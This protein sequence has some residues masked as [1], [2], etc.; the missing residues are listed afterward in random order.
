M[1]TIGMPASYSW[2]K[3]P[4]ISASASGDA[5]LCSYR[6]PAISTA[7]TRSWIA[8]PTTSSRTAANSSVLDRPRIVL[9]TC[10]SEVWRN[11]MYG[12]NAAEGSMSERLRK[13]AQQDHTER[14]NARVDQRFGVP[15]GGM[16]SGLRDADYGSRWWATPGSMDVHSIGMGGIP[17]S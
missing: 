9:P 6:S 14:R 1:S 11:L 13:H 15:S 17:T 10:Q 3:T 12:S 2:M 7:S 4:K 16:S 8:T 5:A